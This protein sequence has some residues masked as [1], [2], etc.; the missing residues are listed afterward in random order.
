MAGGPLVRKRQRATAVRPK[1]HNTNHN[2]I[3]PV[4]G[5]FGDVD[6]REEADAEDNWKS[7]PDKYE[8]G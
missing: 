4:E 7:L 2:I 5:G 1:R 8:D 6:G 3:D